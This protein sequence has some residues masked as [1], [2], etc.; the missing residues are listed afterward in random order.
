MASDV[1]RPLTNE[2]V[3]ALENAGWSVY[4]A[5]ESADAG[6]CLLEIERFTDATGYD[7]IGTLD[8]RGRNVS[9]PSAWL[10]E[11]RSLLDGFDPAEEAALWLG[12]PRA[13]TLRAMLDDF[14]DFKANALASVPKTIANALEGCRHAPA[15]PR[16]HDQG[17]L[18]AEASENVAAQSGIGSKSR[19]N[20]QR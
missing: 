17:A 7:F 10:E 18:C 5:E 3:E 6:G 11:A 1:E 2:V 13:P 15:P 4:I 20:P 19:S 9:D 12:M 8:M 14:E 16:L